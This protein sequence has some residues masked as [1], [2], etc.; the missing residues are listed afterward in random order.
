VK[1][2]RWIIGAAVLVAFASCC[3]LRRGRPPLTVQ[4]EVSSDYGVS[5]IRQTRRVSIE[6]EE[7]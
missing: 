4:G 6:N 5:I 1:G 7:P 2:L 3:G